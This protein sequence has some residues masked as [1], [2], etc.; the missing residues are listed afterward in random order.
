MRVSKVEN[1]EFVV[2]ST[3]SISIYSQLLSV[4]FDESKT[5]SLIKDVTHGREGIRKKNDGYTGL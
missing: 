4:T 5:K 2:K 1:G 3:R